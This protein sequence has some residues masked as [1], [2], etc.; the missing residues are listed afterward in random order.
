MSNYCTKRDAKVRIAEELMSR[1]WK[2]Y[3]FHADESDS[4]TD[5]YSPAYWNGIAEKNGYILVVDNKYESQGEDIKKYNPNYIKINKSDK[6]R[7]ESLKNMTQEN[8]ATESEERN[9]KMLIEKI[10]A[11]YNNEGVSQWEVIG[12]IPAHMGNGKSYSWHV[13]KDGAL[14]DQGKGITKFNDVPERYIFNIN[15]M[16]F[17]EPFKNT[18]NWVCDE[19]GRSIKQ[20]EKRTLT[21]YQEK[22]IKAFKTFILR[23]ERAVNS[24]NTCGDGTE[25]TEREGLEQQ[26]NET[27]EKVIVEKKK[28]VIKPVEVIDRKDIQINDVLSFTY[29]GHYWMV[30]K[31]WEDKKGR[32]CISYECLGSA[33]RGY[34]RVKNTQRYYDLESNLIQQVTEGKI[35]IH[36]IQEVEE[37]EKIEKWVK[38]KKST[39][40]ATESAKKNNEVKNVETTEN[41][42]VAEDVHTKTGEKIF[43]VKFTKT[44]SKEDFKDLLGKIKSIGGYY[45]KFKGGFIF[46]ENPIEKLSS[47]GIENYSAVE[48]KEDK[49]INYENTASYIVENSSTIIDIMNLS[50]SEYWNNEE[51]KNQ[52]LEKI[53]LLQLTKIQFKKV[54]D[55]IEQHEEYS[56]YKHLIEVLK[57]FYGVD[58]AEKTNT[59]NYNKLEEKINKQMD[60]NNIKIERL[61]GDYKTNTW[62]RMREQENRDNQRITLEKDNMYLNYLLNNV[63]E[64]NIND[65][66]IELITRALREE[67]YNYYRRYCD[68]KKRNEQNRYKLYPFINTSWDKNSDWYKEQERR[69][70]RLNKLNINNEYDLIKYLEE[71]FIPLAEAVE[72]NNSLS[73]NEL[74]IKKLERQYKIDQKGDINFTPKELVNILIDYADIQAGEK[75]LEPSAG[76]GNIADELKKKSTNIDVVEYM[77]SYNE[78]LKLK[79]FNVVGND[80]MNYDRKNY[81]DKIVMNPPFSKEQE[82]IKH[83]YECLK[84]GGKIVA[85]TSPHWTFASD[86]KSMEF[87]EWLDNMTYET[88]E[89]DIKFEF[90][91]VGYKILV[92]DKE[93][94]LNSMAM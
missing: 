64:K 72:Q 76:I 22:A 37:I 5:Y 94:N 81:Y 58:K 59:I 45:S 89:S 43:V 41:Y 84:G 15:T 32:K 91:N 67:F 46:K 86:K 29:H 47:V 33:S 48:K 8:G 68:N 78:L 39:R 10:N 71:K 73:E 11:K 42:S 31:I 85:I 44:V 23:L 61:S 25:E 2:V 52:L 13:E 90:T 3:G 63:I 56:E 79:G 7:I 53:K 49:K 20:Y 54:I 75:I 66:E 9:A 77:Y 55:T 28:S 60:S 12:R 14:V 74:K 6:N 38:V 26:E 24:M 51:Y 80:F 87:R 65:F 21:N 83:A 92:I 93:E 30:T 27:M 4:M 34:K 19:E 62:K 36:T 70:K 1:G 50:K 69:I 17:E 16:E 82:H 88:F 40:K 35:K 18:W 57:G